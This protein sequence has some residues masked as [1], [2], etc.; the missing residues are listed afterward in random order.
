MNAETRQ[1]PAIDPQEVMMRAGLVEL[2][3]ALR[4]TVSQPNPDLAR[5]RTL[6]AAVADARRRLAR[7][8]GEPPP[9][10]D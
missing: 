6:R 2:E 5:A 8:Q 10:T 4:A 3:R 7:L 1:D 9:H